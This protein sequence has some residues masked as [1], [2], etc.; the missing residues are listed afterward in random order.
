L[1]VG[2]FIVTII[3]GLL[4][5]PF[6]LYKDS[7]W[8]GVPLLVGAVVGLLVAALGISIAVHN[9]RDRGGLAIAKERRDEP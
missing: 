2:G 5:W 8:L 4:A 7:L 9:H 3:F 1:I 6:L